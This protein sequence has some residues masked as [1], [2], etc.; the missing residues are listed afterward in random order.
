[1]N[2][3]LRTS[4]ALI[5]SYAVFTMSVLTG[6]WSEKPAPT[7]APATGQ[8]AAPAA[9]PAAPADQNQAPLQ[10]SLDDVVAPI[11]LLS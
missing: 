11:A 4:T 7:A 3:V 1:M 2:P 9:A 10:M 8:A 6:C 5:L